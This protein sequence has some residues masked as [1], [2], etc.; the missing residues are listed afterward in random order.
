MTM[1]YSIKQNSYSMPNSEVEM[2]KRKSAAT[3]AANKAAASKRARQ[4]TAARESEAEAAARRAAGAERFREYHAR[5]G[6]EAAAARREENALRMRHARQV[7]SPE[8]TEAR[9]VENTER[10]ALARLNASPEEAEGRRVED[11]ERRALARADATPEEAEGRRVEDAERR[12]RARLEATP[13]QVAARRNDDADRQAR[14]RERQSPEAADERRA[15]DAERHANAR[16]LQ[17]PEEADA[18]RAQQAAHMA[19][20]REVQ[21]PQRAV[22]D[23]IQRQLRDLRPRP[24]V[25]NLDIPDD[26]APAA[27]PAAPQRAP[28]A[29]G[30]PTLEELFDATMAAMEM[31]VCRHCN[32]AVM[33][34]DGSLAPTCTKRARNDPTKRECEVRFTAANRMDPGVVPPELQGL[35]YI[36]QQLIARVHPVVSVYKDVQELA[37][38]LPHRLADLN[39]IITVRTQGVQGAEGH[40]DFN[41]RAGRVRAA[42]VWLK[43]HHRY[44]RDVEISEENLSQLPANGDAYSQ[45]TKERLYRRRENTMAI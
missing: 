18:R 28:A 7:Q 26:V 27:A 42:L 9:R 33:T 43:E 14:V 36:E 23:R 29:A 37:T 12:A 13:E 20:V 22:Q 45:I 39:S 24:R 38:A 34:A 32:R 6:E 41:V 4:E 15:A 19:D 5:L 21:T 8:E 30:Q 44:Y 31:N 11:A 25:L 1:T 40:V 17:T 2:G 16:L 35:T 3:K 10:R